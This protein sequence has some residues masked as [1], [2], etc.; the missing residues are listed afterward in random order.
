VKRFAARAELH[1]PKGKVSV[2]ACGKKLCVDVE[3]TGARAVKISYRDY[4]IWKTDKSGSYVVELF[5]G[6]GKELAMPVGGDIYPFR[7]AEVLGKVFVCGEEVLTIALD[8]PFSVDVKVPLAVE[9]ECQS[10]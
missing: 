2:R 7:L 6:E 3:L 10:F 1:H 9:M 4:V 8:I 5:R